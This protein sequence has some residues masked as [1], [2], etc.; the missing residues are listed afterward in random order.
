MDE[1]VEIRQEETGP[2][3]VNDAE[4]ASQFVTDA[5]EVQTTDQVPNAAPR[6]EWLPDKFVNPEAMAQAYSE[7]EAAQSQQNSEEEY[8]YE[9]D[10]ED[11]RGYYK[12]V[13]HDNITEYSDEYN[14]TGQL[15]PASYQKIESEFGIPEDV[16]QAYVEGQR[17]IQVNRSMELM[18][19]VGGRDS[20]MNMVKW[21]SQTLSSEE[22]QAFDNAL[23]SNDPNTMR[24]AVSG[25]HARYI[26]ETG[27]RGNLIQGQAPSSSS[28]AFQSVA[29]MTEA[30]RDPR[31]RK[32]EAYRTEVQNRLNVSNIM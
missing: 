2:M 15:S 30:M 3:G 10:S 32:D 21:G 26:N 22:Q 4:N 19:S 9:E 17:A 23:K 12:E 6:P 13:T 20:Y 1:R 18:D 8:E 11:D 28:D 31:Y 16:A 14:Q 5:E 7:L 27:R 29:E 24:M 25:M